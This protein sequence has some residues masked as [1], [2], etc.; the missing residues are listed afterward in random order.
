[1]D[2]KDKRAVSLTILRV[3]PRYDGNH[4]ILRDLRSVASF[5]HPAF[6]PLSDFGFQDSCLWTARPPIE[7]VPLTAMAQRPSLHVAIRVTLAVAKALDALHL[8]GL[9][10]GT[11]SCAS[12]IIG[13]GLAG[14]PAR[15]AEKHL[16]DHLLIAH[17]GLPQMLTYEALHQS[18]DWKKLAPYVAP[19][20]IRG[21]QLRTPRADVFSLAGILYTLVTGY[22]PFKG[23]TLDELIERSGRGQVESLPP[24][25]PEALT[26]VI[27]AALD[28][29]PGRRPA[30]MRD[31]ALAVK[32]A[33]PRKTEGIPP[34][35]PTPPPAPKKRP[36]W[37][38][39]AGA[40]VLLLGAGAWF[41]WGRESK[42]PAP[43]P[44][45]DP[46]QA[47][48]R[49]E[50]AAAARRKEIRATIVRNG[51][52]DEDIAKLARDEAERIP[53]QFRDT[54]AMLYH[55]ACLKEMEGDRTGAKQILESA[56]ERYP[57]FGPAVLSW[58]KHQMLALLRV[59]RLEPQP[60]GDDL[61]TVWYDVG[62]EP[63]AWERIHARVTAAVSDLDPVDGNIRRAF[64]QFS[65]SDFKGASDL[66]LQALQTVD[67]DDD[68]FDLAGRTALL[69][70]KSDPAVDCED[71]AIKL[72]ATPD[73]HAVAA[74]A[75]HLGGAKGSADRILRGAQLDP[76]LL[77][78]LSFEWLGFDAGPLLDRAAE[79]PESLRRLVHY[80][81]RF[82]SVARVLDACE[83]WIKL[84]PGRPEP[85]AARG[86]ILAS[87]RDDIRAVEDLEKAISLSSKDPEVYAARAALRDDPKTALDEL[88]RA[89]TLRP[90]EAA[91]LEHR[92][93][94]RRAL[95]DVAGMLQDLEAAARA[96][97]M[98]GAN[99]A[100]LRS[101][102][103]ANRLNGKYDRAARHFQDWILL[104]PGDPWAYYERAVLY[105]KQGKPADAAAD[106]EAAL[107]LTRDPRALK[108]FQM[109]LWVAQGSWG[110]WL[111]LDARWP[112]DLM[113]MILGLQTVDD[114]DRLIPE[115]A[116]ER[117]CELYFYASIVKLR[118]GNVEGA[119]SL[120]DWCAKTRR[121]DLPEF[122]LAASFLEKT[123]D[124]K[125]DRFPQ[126]P[127]S[128]ET[129]ID[130]ALTRM[131]SA[132]Q[133]IPSERLQVSW[134]L[135]GGMTDVRADLAQRLGPVAKKSIEMQVYEFGEMVSCVLEAS[136]DLDAIRSSIRKSSNP[137][138]TPRPF[139]AVRS[140]ARGLV[141]TEGVS[142]VIIL[143][144][145][146]IDGEELEN[147][148]DAAREKGAVVFVLGP[149]APLGA[150]QFWSG[151]PTPRVIHGGSDSAGPE[152]LQWSP[153]CCGNLRCRLSPALGRRLVPAPAANPWLWNVG[154]GDRMASGRGSYALERLARATGGLFALV[155]TPMT[156]LP[157]GYEPEWVPRIEWEKANAA[158]PVRLAVTRVA[159]AWRENLPEF[160]SAQLPV[161]HLE[162]NQAFRYAD[163]ATA[164]L[165][166][167]KE[168]L[169][170]IERS[171]F[172]RHD[173]AGKRWEAI[174]DLLEAQLA[175]LQ[176]QLE[177]Y[178]YAMRAGSIPTTSR[179]NDNVCLLTW[180]HP[181][182]EEQLVSRGDPIEK[183][184]SKAAHERAIQKLNRVIAQH[185]G[186]PW[187]RTAEWLKNQLTPLQVVYY[188]A[189]R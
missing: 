90:G 49:A 62:E 155:R 142:H 15:K 177:E 185:S 71:R 123:P 55:A 135:D 12:L 126:R 107:S 13:K 37:P 121:G 25:I 95:G 93:A 162:A 167:C 114:L 51:V 78:R 170:E 63:E 11:L 81:V 178:V 79:D 187:A 4:E 21:K 105:L 30:S 59:E 146:Q 96:Q 97:P 163:R 180:R 145:S 34:E 154:M 173:S 54:A 127:D 82:D 174:A 76:T 188:K 147:A 184:P 179:R 64:L 148:I 176:F 36:W 18:P 74:I 40:A 165:Q 87:L 92:A 134:V 132:L 111:D 100:F 19:E 31:L 45:I 94:I 5:R 117:R 110:E 113:E 72:R 109:L 161:T 137:A 61:Y 91:F 159:R 130:R 1:M 65:K 14:V 103:I 26:R 86:I 83:R 28:P 116:V 183:R 157:P 43:P 9:T 186:T 44:K 153:L 151:Y 8:E 141:R 166:T 160:L 125:T 144:A 138:G 6:V 133:K 143:L 41:V 175:F 35:L 182:T 53:K 104:D 27:L 164:V 108:K 24:D 106:L 140:V 171:R 70:W 16:V 48:L 32:G 149:E 42:P 129:P 10:H 89:V 99:V 2:R 67:W 58:A 122:E 168:W 46:E 118:A 98:R 139:E 57:T 17:L 47:R 3:G 77:N 20:T 22:A 101:I 73:R 84:T 85:Y 136:R 115:S 39:A 29:E 150:S 152:I 124:L 23:E 181:V 169:G 156:E 88:D 120:W 119:R 69:A 112:T 7:G 158:H 50:Q 56:V 131:M 60:V 68:L 52:I 75:L 189:S 80:R 66:L 33:F 128:R 38:F 172:Q 102:G